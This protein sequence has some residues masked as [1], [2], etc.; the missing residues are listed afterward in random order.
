MTLD[1]LIADD[2]LLFRQGV[3]ALLRTQPGWRIVGEAST[4]KEAVELAQRLKPH[5]VV[6]DVE[7]PELDGIEAA[8]QITDA[9]PQTRIVALSMYDNAHYRQRMQDAAAVA[10]VSK[11]QPIDELVAAINLAVGGDT[12]SVRKTFRSKNAGAK[13]SAVLALNTLS[14]RERTVLRLLAEGQRMAGIASAMEISLK[15]VETYR[16]RLQQKLEINELSDLVRFA[17]RAGLVSPEK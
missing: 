13:A 8:R 4:G 17:I 15:T 14:N 6:M 1:I 12:A 9:L 2:H 3:A 5:V 7:M 11:S 10:Y 16:A